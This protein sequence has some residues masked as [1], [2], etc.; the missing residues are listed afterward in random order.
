MKLSIS[1]KNKIN[2][3]FSN[4]EVLDE[5]YADKI[6]SIKFWKEL[7]H[8]NKLGENDLVFIFDHM[9]LVHLGLPTRGGSTEKN[10]HKMISLGVVI[11]YK[12]SR[13]NEVKRLYRLLNP[14][15]YTITAW[16][17][18]CSVRHLLRQAKNGSDPALKNV[19][20]RKT[21]ILVIIKF[22]QI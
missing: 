4:F 20:R 11:A 13:T 3:Y 7:L 15:S 14:D 16:Q 22:F 1:F 9:S 19:F 10:S 21:R 6:H 18:I 8:E 5:H 12:D 17:V 2:L